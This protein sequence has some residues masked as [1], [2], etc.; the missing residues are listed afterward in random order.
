MRKQPIPLA[1]NF[2]RRRCRTAKGLC[3]WVRGSLEVLP[4]E[5]VDSPKGICGDYGCPEGLHIRQRSESRWLSSDVNDWEKHIA[6]LGNSMA[7]G[8]A[9]R[10]LADSEGRVFETP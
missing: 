1:S 2:N 10:C 3:L 4:P 5:I 9:I 7:S 8:F 6:N